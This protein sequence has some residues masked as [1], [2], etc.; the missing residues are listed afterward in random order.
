MF[1]ELVFVLYIYMYIFGKDI[2]IKRQDKEMKFIYYFG[3][4]Q[5]IVYLEV[6]N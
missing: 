3:D 5:L 1:I 4:L 6:I 2:V